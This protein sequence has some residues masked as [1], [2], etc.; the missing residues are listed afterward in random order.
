MKRIE[1]ETKLL[2]SENEDEESSS[3]DS[4]LGRLLASKELMLSQKVQSEVKDALP[5]T[6]MAV[7]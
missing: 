2:M 6:I 3:W 1:A 7:M 5:T 4:S